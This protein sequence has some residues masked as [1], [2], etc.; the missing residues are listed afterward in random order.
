LEDIENTLEINT[1]I[2]QGNVYDWKALDGIL[3]EL[4]N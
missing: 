4:R 3:R 1:V 2:K